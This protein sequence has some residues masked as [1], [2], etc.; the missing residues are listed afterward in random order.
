MVV[1]DGC[2]GWVLT[3]VEEAPI[4]ARFRDRV[5]VT[6]LNVMSVTGE[7]RHLS[8]HGP[9]IGAL[10][11]DKPRISADLSRH[12]GGIRGSFSD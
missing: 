2:S 11:I 7:K 8:R 1:G 3:W 5:P 6:G 4:P 10:I 12:F 9:G